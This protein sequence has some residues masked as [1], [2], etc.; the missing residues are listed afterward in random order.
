MGSFKLADNIWLDSWFILCMRPANERWRYS[1]TPSLIG[2]AHTQNDPWDYPTYDTYWAN[3]V[4]SQFCWCLADTHFEAWTPFEYPIRRLI[5]SRKVLEPRDLFL[6]KLLYEPMLVYN[7]IIS[8]IFQWNL[9]RKTIIFIEENAFKNVVCKMVAILSQPQW[10]N[11]FLWWYAKKSLCSQ[12]TQVQVIA[13]QNQ[14]IT[15]TNDNFNLNTPVAN[16]TNMLLF[17]CKLNAKDIFYPQS[18]QCN[19]LHITWQLCCHD[20][21]KYLEPLDDKWSEIELYIKISFLLS[22][23]VKF[24][25]QLQNLWWNTSMAFECMQGSFCECVQPM[26]DHITL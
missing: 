11:S 24:E 18:H 4:K 8:N 10:L 22:I 14:S 17:N 5:V 6:A 16:S 12:S 2:W 3:C 13:F 25:Q 7:W 9:N 20:K 26:G 1:V 19:I 21:G 23:H 15:R